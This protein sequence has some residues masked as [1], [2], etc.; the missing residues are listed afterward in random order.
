MLRVHLSETND[1]ADSTGFVC[2]FVW[3]VCLFV[4]L[5]ISLDTV[6]LKDVRDSFIMDMLHHCAYQTKAK[7]HQ[8]RAD[9]ELGRTHVCD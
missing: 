1:S 8:T 7:I 4:C 2:L 9:R 3:G 6:A 5:S